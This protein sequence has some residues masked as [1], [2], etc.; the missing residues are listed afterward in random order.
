MQGAAHVPLQRAVDHLVLLDPALADKG[1]GGDARAEVI[2]VPLQIDDDDL[3]IRERLFDKALDVD[4][5]HC[6]RVPS[7]CN[8]QDHAKSKPTAQTQ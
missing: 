7:C 8:D 5:C 2:A 6:H 3:C 1:C 4:S